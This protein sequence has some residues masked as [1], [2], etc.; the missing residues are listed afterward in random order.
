[1]NTSFL[2]LLYGWPKPYIRDQDLATIFF[3]DDNR[4]YD[5]VKYSIKK[6]LLSQIRRGLYLIHRPYQQLHYDEFEI[7]QAVYGPSYISLESALSYH[8]WI[9]EK[10]N[11]CTSATVKRS[12]KFITDIANFTYSHTPIK[13]FML[14]VR[15]VETSDSTFLIAEPWKAVADHIYI[16]SRS[17]RSLAD[18]I[19]DMRIDEELLLETGLTQLENLSTSYASIKV[20]KLLAKF[21]TEMLNGYKDN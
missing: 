14:Q 8:D 7:A 15:R 18:M 11:A 4:R 13:S 5:T 1:M 9:P 6:G 10:V 12:K 17:W 19:S 20:R 16:H 2:E 21:Y 3:M